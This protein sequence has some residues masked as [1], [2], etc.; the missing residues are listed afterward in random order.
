MHRNVSIAEA[1]NRLT[2]LVKDVEAGANVRLTRRGKLV[3]VLVS[4]GE[5]QRLRKQKQSLTK[6][7]R[8]WRARLPR[9]FEGFSRQEVESLRDRSQ[10]REV[11][12]QS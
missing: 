9:G 11:R 3:A 2:R 5:Y 7:L 1:R 10:G 8:T 6:S 12:L 4:R